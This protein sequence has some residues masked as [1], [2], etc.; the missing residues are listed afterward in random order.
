MDFISGFPHRGEFSY[1]RSVCPQDHLN[2]RHPGSV[3]FWSLSLSLSLLLSVP[4]SLAFSLSLSLSLQFS[5]ILI[6]SLSCSRALSLARALSL[7]LTFVVS[8]ALLTVFVI[9]SPISSYPR[10]CVHDFVVHEHHPP[11]FYVILVVL[12]FCLFC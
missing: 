6:C 4:I 7:Y 2:S 11:P 1:L 12:I 10:S 3:S 9:T 5:F 8:H